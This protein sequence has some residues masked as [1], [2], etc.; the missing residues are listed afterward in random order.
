MQKF[1]KKLNGEY[2]FLDEIDE[3]FTLHPQKYFSRIEDYIEPQMR[4]YGWTGDE[5]RNCMIEAE[6][7]AKEPP[8]LYKA[9]NAQNPVSLSDIQNNGQAQ[10]VAQY[11]ENTNTKY[12][13]E[14][15]AMSAIRA[16]Y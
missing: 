13:D 1:R 6:Y 11:I 16:I 12:N 8:S 9:T 2:D 14:I 4:K 3:A 7:A 15:T 5:I 10:D